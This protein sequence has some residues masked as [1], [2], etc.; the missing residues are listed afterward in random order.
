VWKWDSDFELNDA[1]AKEVAATIA[2]HIDDNRPLVVT[3]PTQFN[4]GS[5][6]A[7][8]PWLS[9]ATI[10]YTSNMFWEVPRFFRSA[11]HVMFKSWFLH[12]DSPHAKAKSYWDLEP[13]FAHHTSGLGYVFKRRLEVVKKMLLSEPVSHDMARSC[14]KSF[15]KEVKERLQNVTMAEIDGMW[16]SVTLVVTACGR[17]HLLKQTMESFVKMNTMPIKECI[18]IEDSGKQGINDFVVKM[19]PFPVK[20]IYNETNIGQ[21]RSIDRAYDLVKTEFLM[22]MEDDMVFLKQGFLEKSVPLLF[23]DPKV[24]CVWLRAGDA[25]VYHTI[26]PFDYGGY[27]RVARDW[28]CGSET[29]CGFTWNSALRLTRTARMH[30]PYSAIGWGEHDCNRK[31]AESGHY[32]LAL[33]DQYVKHIGWESH[34]PQDWK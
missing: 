32:A 18:V 16:A 2:L 14:S 28:R 29:W 6:A 20:L 19:C 7:F 25:G 21:V 23:T 22:H 34:C 31:F 3:I 10:D 1:V 27:R 9:S 17:P 26:E 12:N 30:G 8:E 24:F 33:N 11:V 5:Q 15:D 4:D 13:W